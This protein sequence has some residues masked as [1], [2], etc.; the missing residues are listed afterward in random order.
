MFLLNKFLAFG[1]L[2]FYSPPTN[3]KQTPLQ[4]CWNKQVKPL[5]EQCLSFSFTENK[6]ELEHSFQPWQQTNYFTQGTMWMGRY[7]FSKQDSLVSNGKTYF[8]KTYF[9]KEHLLFLDFGDK[10]LFPVTE[11]M[12]LDQPFT[13]CRYLPVVLINYFLEYNV[14]PDK[15][16]TEKITVYKTKINKTIV[17]LYIRQADKLLE[18][19]TT[20][21]H[22]DLF[23][24]VISSF[25]YAD[26]STAGK[27]HYPKHIYIDKINGKIKDEVT[28]SG[29]VLTK[30][31]PALLNKPVDYKLQP[32]KVVKE[33]VRVE[34]YSNGIYFIELK[35]TD[36]KVMLVEFKDFLLV[37]EAPVNSGNGE[38]IIRE[39]KKMAPNKPIRYFVF[40]HYHPHYLGGL[41][42][43]VHKGAKLI[44]SR[45][46]LEYVTYIA[47]AKHSLYPDSLQL[48]PKPL[49]IEEIKDSLTIADGEQEMKI[50]F[51][52]SKSAHTNDYLLYFFPK[53]KMLFEDDLVWI[54][55]AGPI[56]KAGARQAGLY[57]A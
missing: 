39:A 46:N 33:D 29:G 3:A 4:A 19:V 30:E 26:F 57:T 51:I 49:Q 2:I 11:D 16:S 14:L 41:R 36:D 35:H 21:H 22:D 6:N 1:L 31:I 32:A 38:L 44:C 9:T 13:S 24:D 50:Y 42:A 25:N 15:E 40:G 55:R 8:S 12:L 48:Q 56:T 27:L 20:L 34:K 43:F 52:G 18:K 5:R 53:E 7:G 45:E 23:G 17:S 10:D 47:K 37:A 28:L 54:K